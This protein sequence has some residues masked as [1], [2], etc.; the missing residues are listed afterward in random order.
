MIACRYW[1]GS[2]LKFNF[3]T[4]MNYW[5]DSLAPAVVKQI[6]DG[7]FDTVYLKTPIQEEKLRFNEILY[8]F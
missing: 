3:R 2:Y 5:S 8:N 6:N 7:D 1:G 4:E